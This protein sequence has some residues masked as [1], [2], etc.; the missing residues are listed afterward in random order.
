MKNNDFYGNQGNR[1]D[2]YTGLI[3]FI[4]RVQSRTFSRATGV[5]WS[6]ASERSD[7]LLGGTSSDVANLPKL[8]TAAGN[9]RG[10]RRKLGPRNEDGSHGNT[11]YH[12]TR[13]LVY[14]VGIEP[15]HNG[16]YDR[17]DHLKRVNSSFTSFRTHVVIFFGRRKLSSSGSFVRV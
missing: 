7:G 17:S 6:D 10:E 9:P 1:Q 2:R 15:R 5:E 3:L 16:R 8:F 13:M 4:F 14:V 12:I 11:Y